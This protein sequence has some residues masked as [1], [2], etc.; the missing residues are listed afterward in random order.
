MKGKI[1]KNGDVTV[2]MSLEESLQLLRILDCDYNKSKSEYI[3]M[4][5]YTIDKETDKQLFN[6]LY[7]I[8]TEETEIDDTD[9]E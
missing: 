1:Q 6:D 9:K 3:S 2:K 8:V 5:G 7:E 4:R